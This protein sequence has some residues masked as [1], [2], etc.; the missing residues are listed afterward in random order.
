[1]RISETDTRCMIGV[2]EVTSV[3]GQHSL[4]VVDATLG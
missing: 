2:T 3:P 1:M 4:A